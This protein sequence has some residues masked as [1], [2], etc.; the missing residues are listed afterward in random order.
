MP[1][2]TLAPGQALHSGAAVPIQGD[3]GAILATPHAPAMPAKCS[4]VHF[5]FISPSRMVKARAKENR[6][7]P[8]DSPTVASRPILLTAENT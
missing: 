3:T 2:P 8:V 4:F 6:A 1:A 5:Y 7:G